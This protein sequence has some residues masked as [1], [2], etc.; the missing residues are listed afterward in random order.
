MG[1]ITINGK[2]FHKLCFMIPLLIFST[3]LNIPLI[4]S[5]HQFCLTSLFHAWFLLAFHWV[6]FSPFFNHGGVFLG[7]HNMDEIWEQFHMDCTTRMGDIKCILGDFINVL[8]SPPFHL[9]QCGNKQLIKSLKICQVEYCTWEKCIWI[10]REIC[11][12]HYGKTRKLLKM[13]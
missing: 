13:V 10:Q 6:V 8:C 7:E 4:R 3:S 1:Y 9:F 5:P 12:W 11:Q 2:L